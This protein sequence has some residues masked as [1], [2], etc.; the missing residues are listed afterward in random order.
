VTYS[1]AF[2]FCMRG[3]GCGGHPAF[4]APSVL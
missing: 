3:Y 2:H 1:Y 4:P